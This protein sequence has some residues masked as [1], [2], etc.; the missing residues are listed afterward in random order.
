MR[1]QQ[2]SQ[3]LESVIRTALPRVRYIHLARHA[4][5]RGRFRPAARPYLH[6][7]S[8]STTNKSLL[9]YSPHRQV[10][11]QV[12]TRHRLVRPASLPKARPRSTGTI[13]RVPPVAS[14]EIGNAYGHGFWGL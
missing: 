2:P 11:R 4:S 13:L 9:R 5:R 10:T 7:E 14:A 6:G 8:E 1:E 3:D 12:R